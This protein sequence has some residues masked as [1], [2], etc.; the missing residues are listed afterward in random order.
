MDTEQTD[1]PANPDAIWR[2]TVTTAIN[3]ALSLN[4]PDSADAY[5]VANAIVGG[6]R[7]LHK[8]QGQAADVAR[9]VTAERDELAGK[10]AD[11]TAERDNTQVALIGARSLYGT[12]LDAAR[13]YN[14]TLADRLGV[15]YD[16]VKDA[17]ALCDALAPRL[18]IEAAASDAVNFLVTALPDVLSLD[19]DGHPPMPAQ[20]IVML[21]EVLRAA[22]RD[23]AR[24]NEALNV[25]RA[26]ADALRSTLAAT[27]A[28]LR[29]T[30]RARDSWR[31]AAGASAR[32]L[33]LTAAALADVAAIR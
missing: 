3:E 1:T 6:V 32:A 4:L 10:L 14:Q 11:V 27:Q 21:F 20:T 30:D 18:A 24:T 15:P 9:S 16:T 7:D 26:E 31:D 28:D 25:A 5:T 17:A 33:S 2:C 23:I 19:D 29:A 12:L 8:W 13:D 22:R